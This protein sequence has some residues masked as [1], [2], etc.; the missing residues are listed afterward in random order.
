[1]QF[2]AIF[3]Y[4][5]SLF[6]YILGDDTSLGFVPSFWMSLIHVSCYYS[7]AYISDTMYNIQ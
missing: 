7:T 4:L 5:L 3:L 2:S 6:V 1:M